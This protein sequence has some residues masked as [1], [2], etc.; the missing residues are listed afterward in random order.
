MT[1]PTILLTDP[2]QDQAAAIFAILAL[3]QEFD[4][5]ALIAVA[6][7]RGLEHSVPNALKLL[8]LACR[9]DI[10]VHAGNPR[11]LARPLV[12]AEHGQG[13]T[14][15][16]GA[17]LPRRRAEVQ[18]ESGA[19]AIIRLLSTGERFTILSLSPLTT[20]ATAL[21]QQPAIAANVDHLV[22]MA[23]AYF[24]GGNTTPAAEF[25]VYADPEAAQVVLDA[26]MPMTV[27]PLDVTH[28]ML[29][30][31]ARLAGFA[32]TG[33]ACGRA[34]AGMLESSQDIDL[35]R[36]GWD[37]APLHAPCVPLY[38]LEP[39]RFSGRQVAM[40]IETKSVLARGATSVDWWGVTAD[41]PNVTYVTDGDPEWFYGT[42]TAL[43]RT[44][45]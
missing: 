2:G 36:Y 13:L 38:V 12:T 29:S 8:E 33:T 11:P 7:S 40:R 15:L 39:D 23:G 4:V 10:P 43:Y 16:D 9:P 41:P 37:G 45:P 31:P 27:V 22:A 19:E 3:P 25:N 18:P 17:H 32:Q 42:L 44:L 34:V 30:L 28:R 6:G 5:R 21:L 20:L 35:A 14:G 26:D 24:E 1:R